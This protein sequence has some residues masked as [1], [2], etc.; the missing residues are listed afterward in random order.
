MEALQRKQAQFEEDLEAQLD[1]L[2]E[3]QN[4]AEELIQQKHYDSNTIKAKSRA[5]TLRCLHSTS[6][7]LG[8]EG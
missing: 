2:H 4:L 3:V 6:C 1:H 8:Q 5:L 7:W